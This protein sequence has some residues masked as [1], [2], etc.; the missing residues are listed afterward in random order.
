[1]E[2]KK[3]VL[4]H[5]TTKN[6]NYVNCYATFIKFEKKANL[7]NAMYRF[8]IRINE[9]EFSPRTN[10][11]RLSEQYLQRYNFEVTRTAREFPEYFI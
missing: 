5:I 11:M 1:M 8:K 3:D 6:S 9:G 7:K 10:N 4:Y 2:F